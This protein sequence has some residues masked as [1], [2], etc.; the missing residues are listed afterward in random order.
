MGENVKARVVVAMSGGVDSSTAAALLCEQGWEVLG[1]TLRVWS[2]EGPA[3]CGS[4]CA[5]EDIDDARAVCQ[6]LGIPHYV[7]NAED[8]FAREVVRPFV[9]EYLRGR[10]PVPCVACNRDVKFDFLLGRARAL[11]ARLATGH[12]ARLARTGDRFELRRAR[13]AAKDQSYFLYSLGQEELEHLLFPVGDLTKAE[14]RA[15][16][17][18]H[19][20]PTSNKPESQEICFI[21]DG[22]YASFIEKIAGPQPDGEIVDGSGRVLG[23]HGGIHRFTVGQ[24][25]GL[26]VSSRVPLY[27]KGIEVDSRRVLV[28]PKE[29]LGRAQ[30]EVDAVRW[31]AGSPPQRALEGCVKIRHRSDL[32]AAHITPCGNRAGVRLEKPAPAVTPGQM[33]VFYSGDQVL[34]G[35]PIA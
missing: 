35:G 14:V 7:A 27:V 32:L 22:D 6:R 23:R 15:V 18:R 8:I 28:A 29:S 3:R 34:G 31:I 13:D 9:D 30:F 20:L 25:R 4:C 16:A 19:R 12:Y 10:T 26:A 21:P 33:A 11:G 2:Q 1:I 5:P 17:A 24:R